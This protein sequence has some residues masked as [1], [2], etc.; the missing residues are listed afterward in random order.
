MVGRVVSVH[1]YP[2]KSM[3]GETLAAGLIGPGG[4]AGDRQWAVRDVET[5]TLASAKRRRLWDGI[6]DCRAWYESDA[7]LVELPSGMK[8]EL[9]DPSAA[10]AL[11]DLFGREVT[12]ERFGDTTRGLYESD[13]PEIDGMV[14]SGEEGVQFETNDAGQQSDGFVDVFP[15]HLTTTSGL[16][17]LRRADPSLVVD[18][19]RFRPTIVIDTGTSEGFVENEWSGR[20]VNIGEAA[21]AVAFPTFRCA[22]A[23]AA[24]GDLPRQL[25]VLKTLARING[26]HINLRMGA[27][28]RG[29]NFGVWA[30]ISR[31]GVVRIGDSA[32]VAD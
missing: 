19:R 21:F 17:A 12:L 4:L 29:A 30:D 8:F 6:L 32:T 15:A 7:P 22:M 13:W 14:L 24:Q 23:T 1:R 26:E 31:A 18:E 28:G 27:S 9:E 2:V 25:G 11:S 10:V 16:S 20:E 5:G 3:S